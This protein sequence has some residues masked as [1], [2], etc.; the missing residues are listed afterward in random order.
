MGTIRRA[1]F[2]VLF[3]TL[4]MCSILIFVAHSV[5]SIEENSQCCTGQGEAPKQGTVEK[6]KD[7]T[8]NNISHHDHHTYILHVDKDN[9]V[10][11]LRGTAIPKV[12]QLR[13][14]GVSLFLTNVT[15]DVGKAPTQCPPELKFA[16][17]K[18]PKTALFSAPGC[19]NTWVRHLL[20]VATGIYYIQI[21]KYRQ[22][23][24][25]ICTRIWQ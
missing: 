20:Q 24:N 10:Q 9:Q 7:I 18:L 16:A 12:G 25:I 14:N 8:K 22:I 17:V 19:G 4:F 2:F 5:T 23:S 15:T 21:V 6:D 3:M 13:Q 1:Y 11:P